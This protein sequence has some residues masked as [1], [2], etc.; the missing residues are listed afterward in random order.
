[1]Q[2]QRWDRDWRNSQPVD[3]AQ[4]EAYPMSKHQSLRLLIIL[5]DACRLEPS[6]TV[7]WEALPSSR[8]VRCRYPQLNSGWRLGTLMEELGEGWKGLKGMR[9]PQEDQP[10]QLTWTLGALRTTKKRAHTGRGPLHICS[11]YAGQ[12]PCGPQ[13]TGAKA[14]S[15]AVACL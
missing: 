9:T 8:L 15:I 2:G 6:I 1:M 7:L 3:S 11:R 10:C 14:L 5:W 4:Y 12:S 13:T